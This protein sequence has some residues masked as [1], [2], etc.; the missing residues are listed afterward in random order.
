MSTSTSSLSLATDPD[1]G[2]TKADPVPARLRCRRG[3]LF[4]TSVLIQ[5]AARDGFDP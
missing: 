5:K 4:L 1:E 3:P 2:R